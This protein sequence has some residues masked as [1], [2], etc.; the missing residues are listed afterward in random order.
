M[1][2]YWNAVQLDDAQAQ[3]VRRRPEVLWELLD[4]LYAAPGRTESVD[5][6]W[7]LLHWALTAS[8]VPTGSP[9]S[10]ALM[11]DDVLAA[12]EGGDNLVVL[13]P[14]SRVRETAAALRSALAEPLPGRLDPEPLKDSVLY[15][16]CW[17]VRSARAQIET[18]LPVLVAFYE[19]AARGSYHVGHVL[20]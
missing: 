8:D 11:S 1:G 18:S 2:I 15:P 12:D 17:D 16:D 6:A 3:A 4:E 20:G 10:E 5:K 14:P 9:L 13:L 7:H 19:A